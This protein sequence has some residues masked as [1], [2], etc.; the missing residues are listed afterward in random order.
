M[1][2]KKPTLVPKIPKT[3][4]KKAKAALEAIPQKK[5]DKPEYICKSFFKYDETIKKQLYAITVET[6]NQ[7]TSFAYEISVDCFH[8]RGYCLLHFKFHFG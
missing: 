1:P 3:R 6:V 2:L 4:K 5:P 8:D 7:F